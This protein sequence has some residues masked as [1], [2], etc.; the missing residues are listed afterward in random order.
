MTAD[1]PTI[2]RDASP[3]NAPSRR[4]IGLFGGRFD[5]VHRAHLTIA[6]A[7]ADQLH[8]EQVR[9]IVTGNPVHK[10]AVASAQHRLA[11]TRCALDA[12]ND[13]RMILDDREVRAASAGARN[14]TAD[15]VATLQHE[16]PDAALILIL[17]EDQLA[18]FHTWSRW[19][20]L[21]EQVT[22]AVCVRP[23]AQ[24]QSIADRIAQR[25]GKLQWFRITPDAM[26]STRIREAL[27]HRQPTEGL[28]PEAVSRYIRDHRLYGFTDSPAG[29]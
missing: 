12:L 5:P 18:S 15:T 16:F 11:M 14:Y 2:S 23:N 1:I 10:P 28:L 29:R 9:W 27:A 21:L 17:G 13:A 25:G 3:G 22:L 19:E 7:A 4:P 8:L 26:S 20:W 24:S 6:Q